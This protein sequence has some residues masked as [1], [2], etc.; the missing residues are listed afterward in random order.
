MSDPD[1]DERS[2][3]AGDI[4]LEYR[5]ETDEFPVPAVVFDLRS[6]ATEPTTARVTATLPK[7]VGV[8]DV[9]FHDDHG[10]DHWSADGR[11][12]RFERELPAGE[13]YRT[14]FAVRDLEGAAARLLDGVSLSTPD[15]TVEHGSPSGESALRSID[16]LV[17]E[18]ADR[19]VKELLAGE[20]DTLPG[21][22]AADGPDAEPAAESTSDGSA[23]A[24]PAVGEAT[25]EEPAT[26]SQS[27]EETPVGEPAAGEPTRE[28]SA[29][30]PA[31]AP[32]ASG[33]SA[34]ADGGVV[35]ALIAELESEEIPE[36]RRETLREALTGSTRSTEA[37]V[38]HL[39]SQVSELAAYADALEE[40]IDENGSG[41]ELIA[42]FREELTAL[43]EEVDELRDDVADLESEVAS[44]RADVEEVSGLR[45]ELAEVFAGDAF[46]EP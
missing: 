8:D 43:D 27:T 15:G 39:Q 7:P 5:V 13:R 21:L 28:P 41:A 2:A 37:R 19:A 25:A 12:L 20:R 17:D 26:A 6:E 38:D 31:T 44:L 42:E 22:E 9:G 1:P 32:V 34:I 29:E 46:E 11:E 40:F 35:E 14:L 36:T 10:A 30:E 3:T 18:G 23:A 24:E 45:E 16:D 33:P 4:E